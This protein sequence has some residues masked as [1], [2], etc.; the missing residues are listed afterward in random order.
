MTEPLHPQTIE[1]FEI[2]RRLRERERAN[3]ASDPLIWAMLG[4]LLIAFFILAV[5]IHWFAH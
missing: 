1:S 5:S 2:A 4:A 3:E